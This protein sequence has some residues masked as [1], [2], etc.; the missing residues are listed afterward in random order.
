MLSGGVTNV[1][2][3]INSY[4]TSDAEEIASLNAL[5]S[6]AEKIAAIGDKVSSIDFTDNTIAAQFENEN[7]AAYTVYYWFT[8]GEGTVT[9]QVYSQQVNVEEIGTVE[10]Y[11]AKLANN[12]SSTIY[13]LTADLDFSAGYTPVEN[14]YGL[15][16]GNGHTISLS[17]IHI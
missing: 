17:L 15:L 14:L 5:A 12:N 11:N 7:K 2:G 1:K 9:S 10:E 6:D 3:T 4:S 13:L 16:N 8:N